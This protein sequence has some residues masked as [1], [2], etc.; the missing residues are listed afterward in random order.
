M[1]ER[2]GTV[3]GAVLGNAI[4]TEAPARRRSTLHDRR[5]IVQGL[6]YFALGMIHSRLAVWCCQPATG[7]CFL[8]LPRYKL[9]SQE[10]QSSARSRRSAWVC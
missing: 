4:A 10:S 8:F 5:A 1:S 2:D 6:C 7:L 9:F 3:S